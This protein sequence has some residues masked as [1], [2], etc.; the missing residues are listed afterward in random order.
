MN[1]SELIRWIAAR[2]CVTVGEVAEVANVSIHTARLRLRRLK[3]RGLLKIVWARGAAWWC[4]PD[5]KPPIVTPRVVPGSR[6]RQ[7]TRDVMQKA[8]EALNGGC[9]TTA[10]LMRMLGL[11][12]SQAFY[13]LRLLQLQGR[14]VEVALGKVALWCR[15]R[16]TAQRFLGEIRETVVRLVEANRLRYVRPKQL[17]ELIT[18][19]A[20]AREL[21][22]RIINVKARPS[23]SAFSVLVAILDAI[24]GDPIHRSIYYTAKPASNINIEIRDGDA[25]GESIPVKLT[26]DLAEALQGAVT[27]EVVLQA[28]EQLLQKFRT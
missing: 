6:R 21:F 10:A 5:A 19:D 15:D 13:A 23:A 12:H 27:D 1:R 7:K 4:V 3:R 18:R 22:S 11:S 26:P 20:K 14:A 8:E 25:V 24:Y 28:L 16:E 2:G 17:F 9:V